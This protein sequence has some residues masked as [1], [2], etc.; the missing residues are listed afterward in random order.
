MAGCAHQM[1]EYS[2][3]GA[4][5]DHHV[6]LDHQYHALEKIGEG[7]YGVVYKAKD[8]RDGT[9]VALKKIRLEHEDEGVPSTAIR[10]MA[11][12]RDLEHPNIVRLMDVVSSQNKLTLIFEYLD[13]DLKQLLDRRRA[14][15]ADEQLKSFLFQILNGLHA[16]HCH[17]LVHRDMKPQNILVTHDA[18]TLK[19]ADFGLAR[20]VIMPMRTY[21]H[22]VVTLWYRPPEILL[23]EPHYLSSVDIWSVG[24]IF[25]E[26]AQ[27]VALFPGDSEIDTLL[28]IFRL[29]G[30]PGE[31]EW[32]GVSNLPDY[33]S[34]FPKWQRAE[35]INAFLDD[36]GLALLSQ[37]L[38][39]RPEAR[40]SAHDAMCDPYLAQAAELHG[41]PPVLPIP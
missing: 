8:K 27:K 12:L 33:K 7:T 6:H 29:L 31:D 24:C 35:P 41:G 11:V 10:E 4:E 3:A 37:M 20:A 22:E 30:T 36:E 1:V 2:A 15:I 18:Q 28:R 40:I 23:G 38:E 39:Y 34:A 9:L 16:C 14:G 13:M 5:Y 19:L 25:G 32:Q 26:M 17:R 21:T